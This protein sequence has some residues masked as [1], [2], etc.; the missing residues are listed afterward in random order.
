LHKSQFSRVSPGRPWEIATPFSQVIL[1]P[2]ILIGQDQEIEVFQGLPKIK[3]YGES[4]IGR[5]MKDFARQC[6]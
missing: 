5:K 2:K 6:N 4:N 3:T 1:A